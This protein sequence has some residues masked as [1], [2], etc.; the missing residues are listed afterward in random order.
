MCLKEC[1]G[2]IMHHWLA[3][4]IRKL[5]CCIA[6]SSL[7]TSINTIVPAVNG[8]TLPHLS[9][10]TSDIVADSL[11][12]ALSKGKFNMFTRQLILQDIAEQLRPIKRKRSAQHTETFQKINTDLLCMYKESRDSG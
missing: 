3:V 8:S 11:T 7:F 5:C 9:R 12:K 2:N 1:I 6:S 4:D 10:P